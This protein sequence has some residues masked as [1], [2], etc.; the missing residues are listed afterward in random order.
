MARLTLRFQLPIPPARARL[1]RDCLVA[2]ARNFPAALDNMNNR[3][4]A[5]HLI[6]NHA[7]T[8]PKSNFY[9][10][11]SPISAPKLPMYRYCI[12]RDRRFCLPLSILRPPFSILRPP[13]SILR[14]PFTYLIRRTFDCKAWYCFGVESDRRNISRWLRSQIARLPDCQKKVFPRPQNCR[15]PLRSPATLRLHSGGGVE[16]RTPKSE[17]MPNL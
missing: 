17:E 16:C 8:N 13:F 6:R 15:E 1:M 14:P 9:L 12:H 5:Q 7:K 3:S 2:C 4:H 11:N 10:P